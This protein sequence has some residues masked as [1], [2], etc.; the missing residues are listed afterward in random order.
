MHVQIRPAAV[1]FNAE[2]SNLLTMVQKRIEL[3]CRYKQYHALELHTR[4]LFEYALEF[5]RFLSVVYR[6]QLIHALR[7]EALWYI[8]VF[9][10]H[11]W[12][13]ESFRLMV[14]SWIIAI[15]GVIKPP[16]C[17]EL[18]KPLKELLDGLVSLTDGRAGRS[19]ISEFK[20]DPALIERLM[21]GEMQGARDIV[22]SMLARLASPDR[23][24]IEIILPAMVEIGE[25][26]ERNTAE[27][28]QEHLATETIRNLLASLPGMIQRTLPD[29]KRTAIVSCVPGDEHELIPLALAAYLEIRG[30]DVKNLGGNLPADQIAAAVDALSPHAV[31]L[32]LTMLSRLDNA[33]EVIART[34]RQTH[35]A[36]IIFGGRGALRAKDVLESAGAL[37]AGDFDEGHHL[38]SGGPRH[39]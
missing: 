20:A 2:Y 4:H 15:E 33:M 23:L 3:E 24:I 31:F 14:D 27:V 35:K 34:Q 10:S 39:A 1:V 5:G 26:W 28:F 13:K 12:E 30:W 22:S 17:N 29:S 6:Y 18:S 25:R 19:K 21:K 38:G 9:E 8:K 32:T 16:E 37:V 7:E 36:P 11:G